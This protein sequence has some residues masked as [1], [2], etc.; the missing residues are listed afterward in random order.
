MGCRVWLQLQFLQMAEQ[1]SMW[2]TQLTHVQRLSLKPQTSRRTHSHLA[3]GETK[4]Q[5]AIQRGQ[6]YGLSFPF[7]CLPG[8]V[9]MAQSGLPLTDSD[10]IK[11]VELPQS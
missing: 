4:A 11:R 3:D 2:Q 5:A 9:G 7:S 6:V 10:H 8:Q 1:V